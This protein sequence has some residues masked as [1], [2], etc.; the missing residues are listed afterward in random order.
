MEK[1]KDTVSYPADM[2]HLQ[3]NYSQNVTQDIVE[4]AFKMC[5]FTE[6][7]LATIKKH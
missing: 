7:L 4:E 6:A 2:R 1:K 5:A 3:T